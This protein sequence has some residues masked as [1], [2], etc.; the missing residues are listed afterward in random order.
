MLGDAHGLARRVIEDHLRGRAD[1]ATL[2]VG[3]VEGVLED[4]RGVADLTDPYADVVLVVESEW[5]LVAH[6][7]L[8]DREV[9][10][11][12]EEIVFVVDPEVPQVRDAPDLGEEQVVRV[13]DD[14]LEV[15]LAEAHALAMREGVFGLRR[16]RVEA[17]RF[18]YRVPSRLARPVLARPS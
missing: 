2:A 6:A 10:A 9:D 17:S 1:R 16:H 12:L 14:P 7:R 11:L 4:P 5:R 13:V 18:A 15:R 8:S 3:P